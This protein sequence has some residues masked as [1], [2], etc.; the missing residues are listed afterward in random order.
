MDTA[1]NSLDGFFNQKINETEEKSKKLAAEYL[2]WVEKKTS[3]ILKEKSFVIPPDV[4]IIR[5]SVFWMDF[6]YNIDE[7]YGGRHP[8]I[9]LRR[10]GNTAIVLPLST[11]EPT[12]S[13][14]A[15]GVYVEIK[16]VYGFKHFRRW[17]NVLNAT[18]VSIQR[19]TF[20]SEPA[21]IKGPELDKINEAM[22]KSGLWTVKK[23]K[24]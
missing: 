7:E 20:G 23:K 16:R 5:G 9:V 3:L 11:Q 24:D 12:P 2:K 15:S 17:V 8:G 4:K 6:G 14:L 18:P 1:K 13:Q 21:N 22:E 19:F 10:G